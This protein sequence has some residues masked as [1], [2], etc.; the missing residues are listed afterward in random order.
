MDAINP[1]KYGVV[2]L[3]DKDGTVVFRKA[4]PS[5]EDIRELSR[6]VAALLE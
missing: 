4:R 5:L 6:K 1:E 2:A 3:Y